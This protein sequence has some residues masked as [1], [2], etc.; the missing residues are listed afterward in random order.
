MELRDIT[1]DKAAVATLTVNRP[2]ALNALVVEWVKAKAGGARRR[3]PSPLSGLA[4]LARRR[5]DVIAA[6]DV[7][8]DEHAVLVALFLALAVDRFGRAAVLPADEFRV[9]GGGREPGGL[10]GSVAHLLRG[11]VEG[12][13][14]RRILVVGATFEVR[15]LVGRYSRRKD[16]EQEE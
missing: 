10:H 11:V 12:E 15:D 8:K 1:F 6:S 7:H 13:E 2:A 5:L 16:A 14:A 4:K 9:E 3:S